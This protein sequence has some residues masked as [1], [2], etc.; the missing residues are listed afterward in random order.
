MHAVKSKKSMAVDF[1]NED[2]L[3]YV[4]RKFSKLNS[5]EI[6]ENFMLH[7]NI[8]LILGYDGTIVPSQKVLIK[9]NDGTVV[10]KKAKVS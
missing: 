9:N 4:N 3:N 10:T 2:Q 7:N 5:T 1:Y 6:K 8:M